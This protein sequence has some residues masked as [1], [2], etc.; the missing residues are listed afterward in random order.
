MSM[1][2]NAQDE[3]YPTVDK[4][5]PYEKESSLLSLMDALRTP[6][7]LIQ[8]DFPS[9]PSSVFDKD[10][11]AGALEDVAE[12][13]EKLSVDK[14]P[15]A[16]STSILAAA[17]DADPLLSEIMGGTMTPAAYTLLGNNP[18]SNNGLNPLAPAVGMLGMGGVGGATPMGA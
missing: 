4:T 15:L 17:K 9:T 16:T 14:A 10:P 12:A 7:D 3:Q 13:M 18:S 11:G 2:E 6:M 1:F 8:A 5:R